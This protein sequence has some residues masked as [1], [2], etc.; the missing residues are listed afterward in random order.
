MINFF[1]S[2]DA[3]ANRCTNF[4]KNSNS[5]SPSTAKTVI[6]QPFIELITVESTNIYAIDQ[7]KANLAAHGT[8]YFA[9]EQTAGKGQRG[10]SWQT[11]P[12]THIAI[13]VVVDCSFLSLSEQFNLN[14][15][16]ALAAHDFFSKYAGEE[17]SVKWPNDLYWRDRKAGGILIE[18]LVRGNLWQ[19]SVIGIG[20]NLNQVQFP[21]TMPNPVS[22]KQITGRNYDTVL[23]AK[24]LCACLEARYGQLENRSFMQMLER[25]NERLYKRGKEV[26]LKKDGTVF[27]AIIENVSS[28]GE[29][30]V[31]GCLQDSFRF[32]EVEW[33]LN[34]KILKKEK[35]K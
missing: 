28:G 14:L 10:K 22:L 25:Y 29:L 7:L 20:I 31:S 26:K 30:F 8:V 9:H 23:M 17:S 12:G 35:E 18:N 19:G 1:F 13:S 2:R 32:G 4:A 5:L 33:V 16:S 3:K 21:A 15:M 27:K 24:E 34:E 11:Q 6:G